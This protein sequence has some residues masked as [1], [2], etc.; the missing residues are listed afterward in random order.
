MDIIISKGRNCIMIEVKQTA[1]S[2]RRTMRIL[3]CSYILIVAGYYW[4]K[5]AG[6]KI[7]LEYRFWVDAGF[8]IWIWFVPVL[9]VGILL[10]R[11]C[12]RLW[13]KKS[14]WRWFLAIVV[15][16]Y[17]GITAYI[18]LLYFLFNL[19]TLTSDEKMPDGNLVVAVPY[20]IESIHHYAEPVGL[21]FRREFSFDE[22]RTADSLSKIYG[23]RFRPLRKENNQWVYDSDM[24][25]DIEVT[26]IQYGFS[27]AYYLENNFEQVLT[28]K[29][30]K[31]HQDLFDSHGVELVSY[32]YGQ[33]EVNPEGQ[34]MYTAVLVSEENK[35]SAAEAIAEFI[36]VTLMEDLRP[37]GKRTW[38]GLTGSIYLVTGT[39][40]DGKYR[41]IGNIPFAL[42]SQHFWVFNASVTAEEIAEEIVIKKEIEEEVQEGLSE[43]LGGEMTAYEVQMP[44]VT[45]T[46]VEMIERY[47]KIEPSAT[48]VTEE[49]MEYRMVAVDRAMGSSFYVLIATND[50]GKT[51]TI[52]N[53]DPY[54]GSGGEARWITFLDENLGYS[55][56]AHGAGSFGS[57]YRTDDG[58]CSWV[59]VDYPSANVKLS[60]GSFYNPF[61]MPEKVYE[62]DGILYMES[63]QGTDGDYYDAELGFCHGL[64]R[65]NDWGLQWEFIQK[66]HAVRK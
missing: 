57:L 58:G 37:D 42:K 59:M 56:L 63:G 9:F 52:V 30:L 53:P 43:S 12:V 50:Q 17:I 18:S 41:S 51:G 31:E 6:E 45:E 25:P 46:K 60:D 29:I 61:V 44:E 19:F 4:G 39:E 62:E 38:K 20:G 26:N 16:A 33:S 40:E 3:I 64:Y 1:W 15:F 14:A 32:L 21:L 13:K 49:G 24:Y 66:I 8:R 55:C 47:L 48:Y 7:G 2:G 11:A 35:E 27:E 36:K 65:S 23:A 28:S 5:D 10:L 34:G 22:E 54:N